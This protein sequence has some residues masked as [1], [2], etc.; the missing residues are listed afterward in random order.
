[1]TIADWHST[2]FQFL[3]VILSLLT[4]I[5]SVI[6]IFY[7]YQNLKEMRN[8]L[9]E[10]KKQ[11]FEQNRGNLIFYIAKSN[12]GIT[13]DLI[14]KN[15]GN[16]PAK[17]ISLKISPDLEWNKAGQTG[18]DNFNITKLKNIFLAPQQHV[19]TIFDFS[20]FE[21]KELNIEICYST[22]D[23]QFTETYKIDLNYLHKVLRTEPRIEDEL[24][25]LKYINKS[26]C[27][28]SDKFI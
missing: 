25:A 24:Q 8:Q 12:I 23:K 18:I 20:N 4:F 14:I 3:G 17:L 11:Y 5:G 21:E 27:G 2:L 10:Q 16:S 9:S 1:M 15:F 19:G 28:L 13:H 7:T 6:A 26:I 22:C